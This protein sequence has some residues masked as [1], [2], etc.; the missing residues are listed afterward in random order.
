MRFDITPNLS[1]RAFSHGHWHRTYP[2]SRG[3]QVFH[4][5]TQKSRSG[6]KGSAFH[7]TCFRQAVQNLRYSVYHLPSLALCP[8][9]RDT[10]AGE[11]WSFLN[12]QCLRVSVVQKW[13]FPNENMK[14]LNSGR[15]MFPV[16]MVRKTLLI[17][18]NSL[19]FSYFAGLGEF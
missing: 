19:F 9:M 10:S 18:E 13:L 4:E 17:R 11:A 5:F 14:S 16:E 7:L 3:M 1:F 15:A 6:R 2:A 12:T 8:A